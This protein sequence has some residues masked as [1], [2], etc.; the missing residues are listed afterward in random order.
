MLLHCD[1]KRLQALLERVSS[2]TYAN[3]YR[4]K[5]ASLD[6]SKLA[7][8][9]FLTRDEIAHT[10]PDERCYVPTTD[11]VFTAYTSGTSSGHPLLLFFG[12]VADY[13]FNPSFGLPVSRALILYPPLL[14]SFSASFIQQCR[15]SDSGLVP[16]FGDINNLTVSAALLQKFNCDTLFATPTIALRFAA[17]CST[18]TIKLLVVASEL[19][20]DTILKQLQQQFPT[21]KIVNMYASAEV[22]QFILGPT[23]N[24]IMNNTPGFVPN[25][26]ALIAT[27]LIDSELVIT[28]ANN[29]AFPLIRYRT[30]DYFSIIGTDEDTNMPIL[31]LDGRNGVDV[32]RVAG[33]E[34]RAGTLDECCLAANLKTDE[35][36][37][38]V[39]RGDGDDIN[40]RLEV[41]RDGLT[42]YGD[43]HLLSE[44]LLHTLYLA[45]DYPLQKAIQEDLIATIHVQPVDALSVTG[46]KRRPLICTL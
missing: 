10:P 1:T 42:R 32:V 30:G 18:G 14:K 17:H 29:P 35:Y 16:V 12:Q 6:T 24:M 13:Y 2:T 19:S 34:L 40:F 39:E 15:Q 46:T 38:H 25:Q 21:A 8:L 33:F 20:N 7:D 22:G 11:L 3:F 28:Y 4:N 27:E 5:Y 43:A 44:H 26:S 23:K 36:Q 45:K 31:Q 37:L 9:P 41:M